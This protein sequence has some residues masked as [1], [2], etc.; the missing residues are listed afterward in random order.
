[1]SPQTTDLIDGVLLE[2]CALHEVLRGTWSPTNQPVVV[3]RARFGHDPLAAR[4][5]ID[6][7]RGVLR[8]LAGIYGVPALLEGGSNE[9]VMEDFGGCD[10]ARAGLAGRLEVSQLVDVAKRLAGTLAEIHDRGIAHLDLH[11]GNVVVRSHDL[12][13]ELIDYSCATPLPLLNLDHIAASRATP[14]LGAAGF[15][16]P[17][18]EAGARGD[19][20]HR[21]DLYGLGATL[22]YLATGAVPFDEDDPVTLRHAKR[23]QLP[24]ALEQMGDEFPQPLIRILRRLLDP[25]PDRR[26][27]SAA[28]LAHD[29]E[30]LQ[31]AIAEGSMLEDMQLGRVDLAPRPT[32]PRRLVGRARELAELR[33]A[34]GD[35]RRGGG[36]AMFVAGPPGI[37]KTALISELRSEVL[38]SGGRFVSGK[39]EELLRDQPLSAPAS[40]LRE[41][42]RQ[43]LDDSAGQAGGWRRRLTEAVGQDAQFVTDAFPDLR[44]LF[45]GPN[46][47]LVDDQLERRARL[48]SALVDL[49]AAVAHR[50][51]PLVFVLDDLQ[52][53]DHFSVEL[54][55]Q[56]LGAPDVDGLLLIGAYRDVEVGPDHPL[57]ML[58][59]RLRATHRPPRELL[60]QPLDTSML[61]DLASAML[62]DEIKPDNELVQIL[63]ERTAGNP[64]HAVELVL[65]LHKRGALVA[66]RERGQW[67]VLPEV[68]AAEHLTDDLIGMLIEEFSSLQDPLGAL[69]TA[70]CLG[71]TFTFRQMANLLDV[72]EFEVDRALEPALRRGVLR[73]EETLPQ[74]AAGES[75]TIRFAHDRMREA[76]LG[77]LESADRRARHLELA[78]RIDAA[79]PPGRDVVDAAGQLVMAVPLELV[80]KQARAATR[81]L[82]EAGAEVM[83]KGAFPTAVRFLRLAVDLM[84]EDTWE[85]AHDEAFG[86]YQQLHAAL[87]GAADHGGAEEIFAVLQAHARSAGELAAAARLHI[88]GLADQTR[89][90]EAVRFGCQ[91]LASLGVDV[92]LDDPIGDVDRRLSALEAVYSE[93]G[94]LTLPTDPAEA[95]ERHIA[96][97][98]NRMIPVAFFWRPEVA[99]WLCV[100]SVER[101][102]ERGLLDEYLYPAACVT[103]T[104]I[105]LRDDPALGIEVAQQA[106][107]I[108]RQCPET[109]P[110]ELARTHHVVGLFV[111]H[112]SRPLERSI[113]HARLAFDQLARAG[114]TDFACFSFYTTQAAVFDTA[115]G[116]DDV[117]AEIAR[118]E[119]YAGRVG[120]LHAQQ[121]YVNFRRTLLALRGETDGSGSFDGPGFSESAH[122]AEVSANPMARSFYHTYRAVTALLFA[123]TDTLI[124]Q[125]AAAREH[126]PYI[127]GFWP[128][129]LVRL[130]SALASVEMLRRG[131]DDITVAEKARAQ[132]ASD[133]HWLKERAVK[134]EANLGHLAQLVGAECRELEG[135]FWGASIAFEQAAALA[136]SNHRPW[137]LALILERASE[138]QRRQGL[139]RVA[140]AQ[141]LRARLAWQRWG[142]VGRVAALDR[143]SPHIAHLEASQSSGEKRNIDHVALLRAVRSISGARTREEL[144]S[145]S[146]KVVAPLAGASQ[147]RFIARGAAGGWWMEGGIDEAANILRQPL[148][149]AIEAAEVPANVLKMAE[150]ATD[151][152][153]SEDAATD[154]RFMSDPRYQRRGRC[155]LLVLPIRVQNQLEAVLV[156]EEGHRRSAFGSTRLELLSLLAS[157]LASEFEG[158]KVREHLEELVSER[159]QALAYANEQLDA[160][161]RTDA[162]T[163]I[164]NRRQFNEVLEVEWRRAARRSRA[165]GLLLLDIDHF[166][167][168]NDRYGH[169]AGDAALRA[170]GAVLRD[171]CR[172]ANETPT[173]FG[174]EE[175][176]IL[177]ADADV[178]EV[179]WLA[180]QLRAGIKAIELSGSGGLTASIGVA[181]QKAGTGTAGEQR[182]VHAADVALYR[183]KQGGRDRVELCR[184]SDCL[185]D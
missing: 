161:S 4:A 125:A 110:T 100:V 96:W 102:R 99:F 93:Q 162:L 97:L 63:A 73:I 57:A 94:H 5:A 95:S 139:D 175:F 165:V 145:R 32:A 18:F 47:M 14:H 156:L 49:L 54:L 144:V 19:V 104:T 160:L 71:G 124:N 28:G 155:S 1:M 27:R 76:A 35:T 167:T 135:D 146:L 62:L 138:F 53:A 185:T 3:K 117:E 7:E 91:L 12:G 52:W 23:T 118:A 114:E 148:E 116:L 159:T 50:D 39:F 128:S 112:W 9:V 142:A 103:L 126:A 184:E 42:S 66:D 46:A 87:S 26:Y 30:V 140:D 24:A 106:L 58:L 153:L 22:V 81:L 82:G 84:P 44:G 133:E 130:V 141:L 11:P 25:D 119:S 60:L 77:L 8:Q 33:E 41:L 6:R 150:G 111:S 137:Q 180:E 178:R 172:R 105:G 86:L 143:Q 38:G 56:L 107:L 127:T 68:L 20:D 168:F 36:H 174:G 120:N 75:K 101:W 64:F 55:E 48:R 151:F 61:A 149:K 123:D 134:S 70:A 173:R 181:V 15:R 45:D 37:G 166:K 169:Q 131:C 183:A 85:S 122:V 154:P 179:V 17:E 67:R 157:Q 182:L 72:E 16:A 78:R 59:S 92:P 171:G 10:L 164:G 74:K 108:G 31:T 163:G 13:V 176:A 21:A 2:G 129:A 83:Q 147:A 34:L 115:N 158:L 69:T 152:L 80:D 170:V 43:L 88:T 89:Y 132:L 90:E 177:V 113:D 121:A 79:P 40:G 98:I 136:A 109:S 65:G 51:A 29:L